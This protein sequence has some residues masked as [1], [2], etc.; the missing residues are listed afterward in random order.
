MTQH[1][2]KCLFDVVAACD[3]VTSHLAGAVSVQE[4]ARSRLIRSAVEREFML[5]GEAV[6]RFRAE[7]GNAVLPDAQQI[8]RFR[9][10]IAHEYD[11]VENEVVW[12]AAQRHVPKLKADA[13]A[14]LEANGGIPTSFREED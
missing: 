11:K 10:F 12:N 5:I 7:E 14:L 6:N 3:A 9:N 1:A 13:L 8:V 2:K 4:Y